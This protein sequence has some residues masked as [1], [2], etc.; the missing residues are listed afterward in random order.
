MGLGRRPNGAIEPGQQFP[1][2]YGLGEKLK[3]VALVIRC[4]EKFAAS[5]I[6]G[7]EKDSA[8]RKAVFDLDGQVDTADSGHGDIADDEVGALIAA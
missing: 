8:C 6:P 2:M 3:I 5:G 1:G 7:E 4:F